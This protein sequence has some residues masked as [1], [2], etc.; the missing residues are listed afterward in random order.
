MHEQLARF[1]FMVRVLLIVAMLVFA[2]LLE[3]DS[4]ESTDEEADGEEL[5]EYE[6]DSEATADPEAEPIEEVSVE[7]GEALSIPCTACHGVDGNTL[8]PINGNIAGQN[9]K[10]LLKQLRMIKSGERMI[11][12][13][14]GSML[15]LDDDDLQSL[16]KYYAAQPGVVGRVD[17]E[18]EDPE[19]EEI[20]ELGESIYRGG[21][22]DKK[23]AACTACH[24]PSA[25]GNV[26]AGFP[27]LS[28]QPITYL[29]N[30]L[31]A[32]REETRTTDEY[33]GG[34]MR[35]IAKKMT[36]KEIT[37]VSTYMTALFEGSDE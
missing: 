28:G 26:L 19:R 8:I 33:V 11:D 23:V 5:V 7:A 35:D 31:K 34:M 22:L 9:E 20:L 36:D 14:V 29:E 37:A 12:V 16:A 1:N 24:S 32:Y 10:Y 2:L 17:T 18:E 27:R 30:Q 6:Q 13:M 15:E 21:I 4:H 25:D 3:A